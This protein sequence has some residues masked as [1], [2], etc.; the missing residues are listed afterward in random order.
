[1]PQ[2][3]NTKRTFSFKLRVDYGPHVVSQTLQQKKRAF[4]ARE[5]QQRGRGVQVRVERL[6]W[7]F[8]RHS[9][10]MSLFCEALWM[11]VFEFRVVFVC[12]CVRF[13]P[14]VASTF[15]F[16]LL[17]QSTL[18]WRT[19]LIFSKRIIYST[20]LLLLCSV[21]NAMLLT[22]IKARFHGLIQ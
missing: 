8:R 4:T 6:V 14:S 11:C 19:S 12:G 9:A 17:V 22:P 3:L 18:C 20:E 16:T 10:D 7:S 2:E 1:M 21:L 15:S 5:M 13:P